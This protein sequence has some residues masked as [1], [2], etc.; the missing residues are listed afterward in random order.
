MNYP[1]RTERSRPGQARALEKRGPQD[2]LTGRIRSV[3]YYRT[4]A[5][6]PRFTSEHLLHVKRQDDNVCTGTDPA[7]NGQPCRPG[8]PSAGRSLQ[9]ATIGNLFPRKP[10]PQVAVARQ[11]LRIVPPRF[12]LDT[13]GSLG[14]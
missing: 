11:R 1:V 5:P 10:E 4:E 7:H 12:D 9:H 13:R 2:L 14:Q 6:E 8:Y 3:S